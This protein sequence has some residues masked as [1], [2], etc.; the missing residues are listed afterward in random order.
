MESDHIS[1]MDQIAK[2]QRS[3]P[4]ARWVMA[5]LLAALAMGGL[6][7]WLALVT[8]GKTPGLVGPQAA[9][10]QA[11]PRAAVGQIA[12]DFALPDLNGQTVS[13]SGLQGKPVI[14]FFWTTY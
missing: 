8:S 3:Q 9:A 11:L 1:K 12:P 7:Y 2:A 13:L 5:G 14:L 6:L 4:T 10:S